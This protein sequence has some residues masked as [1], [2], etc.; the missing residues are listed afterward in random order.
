LETLRATAPNAL[1]KG[2]ACHFI[3]VYKNKRLALRGYPG[4]LSLCRPLARGHLNDA[5]KTKEK[6]IE[7][8]V[9]DL[10]DWG[11][12]R[13]YTRDGT[14]MG[15]LSDWMCMETFSTWEKATNRYNSPGNYWT[16]AK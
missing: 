8:E 9:P 15:I 1:G 16:S 4:A 11:D 12:Q 5:A 10:N 3:I 7:L 2:L 14:Q 6:F 13:W